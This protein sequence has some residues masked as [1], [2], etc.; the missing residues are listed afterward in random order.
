[1]GHALFGLW[2]SIGNK[3]NIRIAVD[4]SSYEY[5]DK[6]MRL[7]LTLS[8]FSQFEVF[9]VSSA[10]T[11]SGG[12][13]PQIL[14]P[15]ISKNGDGEERRIDLEERRQRYF[16]SS[17]FRNTEAKERFSAELLG[18]VAIGDLAMTK[19]QSKSDRD[20][21][22]DNF[23][24]GKGFVGD[25]S[26]CLS[27][28]RAW[29]YRKGIFNFNSGHSL[30]ISRG[31]AT[32][33]A[34][35]RLVPNIRR[36]WRAAVVCKPENRSLGGQTVKDHIGSVLSR[37]EHLLTTRDLLETLKLDSLGRQ[38][39]HHEDYSYLANYYFGY[40]LMLLTGI[41]DA[42]ETLSYW[43]VCD[44]QKK[45]QR[46]TFRRLLKKEKSYKMFL[47]KMS[48]FKR[49]LA[50]YINSEEVQSLLGLIYAL[51]NPM[52]HEILPS[53]VTSQGNLR[54]LSGDL[55]VFKG[56][57][58]EKMQKYSDIHT[59]SRDQLLDLGAELKMKGVISDK[60][61]V[62]V[63]PILFVRCMLA[64]ALKF[65]ENVFGYLQLDNLIISSAEERGKFDQLGE[66]PRK[67]VKLEPLEKV[68]E[69]LAVMEASVP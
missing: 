65:I 54:G 42:T 26:E 62:W 69:L 61:E 64:E 55:L 63:E 32:L 48:C 37:V 51:R 56:N 43:G 39:S 50:E 29:V 44:R 9:Y 4:G 13:E 35:P 41:I 30:R 68:N 67:K 2:E 59:L 53:K 40:F 33:L 21:I 5:D 23:H 8:L 46:I 18:S 15:R 10:E 66:V 1:V 14:I 7:L 3:E 27:A 52:A 38:H 25:F 6:A 58:M 20:L 17:G 22:R 60:Q 34:L 36:A 12:G 24:M 28:I 57:I 19:L 49:S 45:P 11:S 47:E 31:M 16:F